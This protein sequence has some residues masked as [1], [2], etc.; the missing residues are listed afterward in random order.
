MMM[1]LAGYSQPGV[2]KSINP[3]YQ[4]KTNIIYY[5]IGE[6]TVALKTMQ[7]GEKKQLVFVN[8]HADETTSVQA[9]TRLLASTGGLLIRIENANKRN[10]RFRLRGRYYMF[11]PNRMF[12]R[13]GAMQTLKQLSR[14]S[15][16]AVD[17]VVKFGERFL[18]LIPA[19]PAYVVALHNNTEGKFGINSYKEGEDLQANA[20]A[21]Y[22][23]GAQDPDDIFLT[24][25]S[26]LYKRLVL[27]KY[28]T[29]LQDNVRVKRDGS[30][31]V[32]C[33]E[34]EIP[35]LNCETQ[36]GKYQQY[37][38]MLMTA[39]QHI[40]RIVNAPNVYRYTLDLADGSKP[41]EGQDIYFGEQVV[42]MI[43]NVE[44]MDTMVVSGQFELEK[45]F[46]LFSN[47]DL[48]LLS[49]EG[50]SPRLEIQVDPTRERDMVNGDR[51]SLEIVV[52]QRLK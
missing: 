46:K 14:I 33:G 15:P 4:P 6:T 25:D 23:D 19:D 50:K 34:R 1:T 11:D 13:E 12:S 10:I 43:R 42:G 21:F 32:Y 24:T 26:S 47:M 2:S 30:L 22:S 7:Y 18:N 8:V 27:E 44:A 31:S 28:N 38:Q 48:F 16:E 17:E 45:K 9:A 3:G 36:H 49:R 5:K 37:L 29:I 41:E 51:S 39:T 52:R 20:S 40:E 35:Y